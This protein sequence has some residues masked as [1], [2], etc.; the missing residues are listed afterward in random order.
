MPTGPVFPP[1]PLIY[2]MPGIPHME[3]QGTLW[4]PRMPP[5]VVPILSAFTHPNMRSPPSMGQPGMRP[6]GFTQQ[7]QSKMLQDN[8]SFS[9]G[10][11]GT[12]Q[13]QQ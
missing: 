5:P 6:Y 10:A 4:L 2:N 13:Q 8:S 11:S 3:A 9:P 7:Q 12:L 1:G